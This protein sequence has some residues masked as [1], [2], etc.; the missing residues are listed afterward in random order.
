MLLTLIYLLSGGVVPETTVKTNLVNA[1]YRYLRRGGGKL[2][3]YVNGERLLDWTDASNET[4]VLDTI[5]RRTNLTS[6]PISCIDWKL[7]KLAN[8]T[9]TNVYLVTDQSPCHSVGYIG[10]GNTVT[11]IGMGSGIHKR[12]L[13]KTCGPCSSLWGCI[14]GLHWF[15][16]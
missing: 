13:E 3:Y 9:N 8:V 5:N 14:R 7:D 4:V 11:S 1:Y 12:Y 15:I 16:L 2:S 10:N 6:V